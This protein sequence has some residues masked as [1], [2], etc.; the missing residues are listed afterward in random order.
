MYVDMKT[1][2][3]HVHNLALLYGI[4]YAFGVRF[5]DNRW[6]L[7]KYDL[8]CSLMLS[9]NLLSII[10][11]GDKKNLHVSLQPNKNKITDIFTIEFY[12]SLSCENKAN[13]AMIIN[14]VYEYSQKYKM[15]HAY[16]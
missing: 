14:L 3:N 15:I 13:Y 5:I 12:E 7:L 9:R 16:A 8:V 2:I 6:W 11:V 10:Y 1:M 4:E